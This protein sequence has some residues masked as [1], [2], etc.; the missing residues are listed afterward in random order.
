MAQDGVAAARAAR[1]SR[2]AVRELDP[3][4]THG[5]GIRWDPAARCYHVRDE[6]GGEWLRDGDGTIRAFVRFE[7]ANGEWLRLR[8]EHLEA[9]VREANW[10]S[11]WN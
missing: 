9:R 1:L 7:A 4:A 6:Q 5:Y 3:A 10:V 11:R 8:R 2:Q